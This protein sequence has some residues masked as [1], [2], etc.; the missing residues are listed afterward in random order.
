MG[1]GGGQTLLHILYQPY[2]WLGFFPLLLINSLFFATLAALFSI[3]VSPSSGS[4]MGRCWAKITCFITPVSVFVKGKPNVKS[5]KSYI[6]VANHQTGYDIFLLYGFLPIDFKWL[7]KRELRKIPFIGYASEKVGHIFIDRSSP[8]S[9]IAS[10]QLAKKKLVNGN[11]VLI[12][13]EGTRSHSREMLPFKKGAFKLA[14]D[15]GLDILPVTI[16]DSYKIKGENCFEI[17]PGVAGLT[18]HPEIETMK[19][20]DNLDG[21][22][23]AT[24]EV[25]ERA[26]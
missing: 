15:L 3:L 7:M 12:F 17:L 2:K 18:I 26:L 22:M 8:K 25:I 9:V 6:I 24:R 23:D 21:L 4:F 10:L 13:P 11:S 16:H 5:N 14:F 1:N 20:A 19:Y